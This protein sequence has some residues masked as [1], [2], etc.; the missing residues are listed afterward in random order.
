M[1]CG[2]GKKG[3]IKVTNMK[4]SNY[5]FASDPDFELVSVAV[6]SIKVLYPKTVTYEA[7]MTKYGKSNYG[8]VANGTTLYVLL[9]DVDFY[10]N[11]TSTFGIE[12]MPVVQQDPVP[13]YPSNSEPEP[14]LD[15]GTLPEN[16]DEE[17]DT[18]QNDLTVVSGIGPATD[19][20]LKG[21]GYYSVESLRNV[22][23]EEWIELSNRNTEA[24]YESFKRAVEQALN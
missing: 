8:A 2:C 10:N 24:S 9:T 14:S 6:S 20:K 16:T 18:A 15:S 12:L 11:N 7:F 4:Q 19:K 1:A 5:D 3:G 23:Q 21:L 13:V 17:F 22:T